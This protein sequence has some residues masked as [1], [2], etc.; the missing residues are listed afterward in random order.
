[1]EAQ[2]PLLTRLQANPFRVLSTLPFQFIHILSARVSVPSEVIAR[3]PAAPVG[4]MGFRRGGRPSRY[5]HGES[6][7]VV[8]AAFPVGAVA[9]SND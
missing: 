4:Q 9:Q 7:Q 6:L 1:M 2:E 8:C 5:D 3:G